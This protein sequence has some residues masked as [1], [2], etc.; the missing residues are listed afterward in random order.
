MANTN[1]IAA[2]DLG[3][4]LIVGVLGKRNDNGTYIVVACET[5]DSANFIR[6]GMIYNVEQAA[7]Q[8]RSLFKKLENRIPGERIVR[9]YVGVGGQSIRSI[10]HVVVKSLGA[11]GEVTEDVIKNLDK[12]C[13]GFKPDALEMLA[14][15]PPT[16][17]LDGNLEMNPVGVPCSRIEARYKLIVCRPSL[18]RHIMNSIAVRAKI[19]IIDTFVSPLTLSDVVLGE[20]DKELGCALI[21]FG[22]GVT[23][24]TVF[25]QKCLVSMCVIPLGGNLITKDITSLSIVAVEAERLKRTYGDA[26]FEK[27]D[28]T[29]IQVNAINGMGPRQISLS[30]LNEVVQARVQEILENVY[31]RL[32]ETG[33]MDSLGAGIVITGGGASLK[34][35]DKAVSAKFKMGV[36]Q[37]SIRKGYI[38]KSTMVIEPEYSVAISLMMKGDK[39]CIYVPARILPP[40]VKTGGGTHV[41]APESAIK[42]EPVRDRRVVEEVDSEAISESESGKK[43]TSKINKKKNI[44]DTV[45]GWAN[46]LFDDSDY[47]DLPKKDEKRKDNEERSTEK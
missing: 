47:E 9:T 3:S 28:E 32:E 20:D 26:L 22:A 21:D 11:D 36:R 12:E 41:S 45:A 44:I 5:D 39:N 31:A 1:Y 19:E 43:R 17:Y 25:K 6:R 13:L 29:P 46:K 15:A 23:S 37:A 24:L 2:I 40:I 38:E 34:N 35:L 42:T 27:D 16:Y 14:I 7:H 8:I 4:S 30:S 18:K 10:D 33:M